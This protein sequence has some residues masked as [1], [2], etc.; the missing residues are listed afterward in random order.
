[1]ITAEHNLYEQLQEWGRKAPGSVAIWEWR[2]SQPPT[3]TTYAALATMA[4][5]YANALADE[6]MGEIVPLFMKKGPQLVA[7][8]AGAIG[9]GKAFAVLSRKLRGPQIASILSSMGSSGGMTDSTGLTE[10]TAM[11]QTDQR[12]AAVQWHVLQDGTASPLSRKLNDDPLRPGSC[13]FTSGSTGSPKGVLVAEMDLRSRA[14]AEIECFGLDRNDVLLNALPLSFDVGLNQICSAIY[15]GCAVVMTDSWLPADILRA[16]AALKV[17]GISAVPG[18]WSDMM[19]VGLGFDTHATHSAL[20]YLTVSGGD[21]PPSQLTRFPQMASGVGIFKTYGQSETFRSTVLRPEEFAQRPTSVGRAFASASV[22]VCRS[23]GLVCTAG[24]RGEIVHSGLGTM[25]GYLGESDRAATAVFTGDIGWMDDEGFLYIE[26]RRDGMLKVAGNRVYPREVS[27][28]MLALDG[29]LEAEVVGAAGP[30]GQTRLVAFIVVASHASTPAQ[31]QR[32]I[33]AR[34][35]SFMVPSELILL[36]A[37]PRTAN[38]KPD[39][40]LLARQ[41]AERLAKPAS[42]VGADVE[43]HEHLIKSQDY[44]VKQ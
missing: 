18:I 44:G 6:S 16:A 27:E 14:I 1:M 5:R 9:T 23:D 10:L 36:E 3:A 19:N 11:A 33:R 15:A 32:A 22:C 34:L 25:L 39:R 37:I 29:V 26:G 35:P 2:G 38:G 42:I 43:V 17:T 21:L 30:D 20:R 8:M 41:A 4:A 24:E 31:L 13:L 28:Q 7:A 40:P 12:I